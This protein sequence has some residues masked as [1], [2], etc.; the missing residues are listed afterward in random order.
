MICF[1]CNRVSRRH[2]IRLTYHAYNFG[3]ENKI[4][5]GVSPRLPFAWPRV[6]RPSRLS[7]ACPPGSSAGLARR[8]ARPLG[9]WL[10]ALLR[11]FQM[12]NFLSLLITLPGT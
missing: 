1:Y 7:F 12:I 9:S 11:T 10:V 6:D 5:S 2:F 4:I 3:K 8:L